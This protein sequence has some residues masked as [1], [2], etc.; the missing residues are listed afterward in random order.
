MRAA[1]SSWT[2]ITLGSGLESVSSDCACV[3]GSIAAA[4]TKVAAIVDRVGMPIAA[5]PFFLPVTVIHSWSGVNLPNL[6]SSKSD[7]TVMA[8]RVGLCPP[9]WL[10]GDFDR[11]RVSIACV[12][13]CAGARGLRFGRESCFGTRGR[14]RRPPYRCRM[15]NV[16]GCACGVERHL[17]FPHW[18]QEGF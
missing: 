18:L 3:V 4:A 16:E 5:E 13:G 12:L 6:S 11:W 14:S 8:A 7:T 2:H 10:T 9:C 1:I 17:N 15:R